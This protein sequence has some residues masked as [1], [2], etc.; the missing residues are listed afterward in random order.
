MPRLV[1]DRAVFIPAGGDRPLL[2]GVSFTA[3][4]GECV[5]IVGPSSAG[6]STLLRLVMGMSAP[7]AGGAFLDGTST[8]HWER[9][10]FSRHVGYVPQGL[11]L[12]DGTIAENIAR[13]GA[14][15]A[16]AL[17]DASKRAGLHRVVAVLPQGYATRIAGATLSSG[18]RQRV[19]L[20]RAL[21]SKPGLL[22]LDEPTAFLDGDG[23]AEF[24]RL[25]ARLRAEG[26]TVLL[27]T[28]RPALLA[29]ADKLVVLQDGAVAQCGAPGELLGGLT[30]PRV[31][32]LPAARVPAQGNAS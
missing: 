10:D 1:L 6:K 20:A 11:A 4:P 23:E 22:V 32:L 16:A 27:V 3:E 17:L 29:T 19:A 5:G 13:L 18:Q 25:L 9:E 2:R 31:R 28:H 14:P 12:V 26:T 7:T 8:Y 24:I 15:D 21:Y 30:G